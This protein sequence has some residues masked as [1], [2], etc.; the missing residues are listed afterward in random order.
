MSRK[1]EMSK[2]LSGDGEQ[3]PQKQPAKTSKRGSSSKPADAKSNNMTK[4]TNPVADV[5]KGTF[6]LSADW[7]QPAAQGLERYVSHANF[8]N[9]AATRDEVMAESLLHLPKDEIDKL[10]TT[11]TLSKY[12][13]CEGRVQCQFK[14]KKEPF[15]PLWLTLDSEGSLEFRE[16]VAHGEAVQAHGKLVRSA[17]VL[18]CKVREPKTARRQYTPAIR[19]DLA[20]PGSLGERKYILF[21]DPE[22][23]SESGMTLGVLRAKLVA[24]SYAKLG[25]MGL[26]LESDK[27]QRLRE[28]AE[29][30]ADYGVIVNPE[31]KFRRRWDLLQFFL[32]I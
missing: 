20:T 8:D 17:S 16:L 23:A 27:E 29:A 21:V 22:D 25:P 2:S 10:I 1:L 7:E 3:S 9:E 6:E 19:L 28:I 30:M 26:T 12:M 14:G 18:W 32:L 13:L 11:P 24:C 4:F 5:D 31:G 15:V